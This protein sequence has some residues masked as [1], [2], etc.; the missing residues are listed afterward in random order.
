MAQLLQSL[1]SSSVGW[2]HYPAIVLAGVSVLASIAYAVRLLLT[3]VAGILDALEDVRSRW[4]LM[5][6]R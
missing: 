1:L 2:L 6:N 4:R 5:R 3:N